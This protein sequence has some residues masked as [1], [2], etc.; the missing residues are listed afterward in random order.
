M[1]VHFQQKPILQMLAHTSWH[2]VK[3][4]LP[5]HWY[6]IWT[7]GCDGGMKT[8]AD[9]NCHWMKV[10]QVIFSPSSAYLWISAPIHVLGVEILNM[11]TVLFWLEKKILVQGNGREAAQLFFFFCLPC[12]KESTLK[13]RNLL[14]SSKLVSFKLNPFSS[15]SWCIEE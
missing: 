4:K 1:Y 14:V 12:Q 6:Y 11:L 10:S 7:S 8:Q 9:L 13:R 5:M 3:G 2:H 15:G